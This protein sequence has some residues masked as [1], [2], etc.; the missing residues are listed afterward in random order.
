M[1]ELLLWEEKEDGWSLVGGLEKLERGAGESLRGAV[2]VEV[3]V[4]KW[5][6]IQK[7]ISMKN[8]KHFAWALVGLF[9]HALNII[10]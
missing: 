7:G 1:Q 4:R 5:E 2:L 3:E 10:F 9:V 6:P 8:Y